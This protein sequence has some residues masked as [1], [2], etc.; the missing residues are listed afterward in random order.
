MYLMSNCLYISLIFRLP[1]SPRIPSIPDIMWSMNRPV[2]RSFIDGSF[3][4]AVF[5]FKN[6]TS[7]LMVI[8]LKKKS[9]LV[10]NLFLQTCLEKKTVWCLF[11][12]RTLHRTK[13]VHKSF[14]VS[15]CR[16]CT[17]TWINV[18]LDCQTV[19]EKGEIVNYYISIVLHVCM[20]EV[21]L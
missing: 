3:S 1:N 5:T 15:G 4:D 19:N 11:Y 14:I 17:S 18:F 21:Y 16:I 2:I 8:P 9:K 6:F 7:G 13:K 20:Y 12:I 10:F